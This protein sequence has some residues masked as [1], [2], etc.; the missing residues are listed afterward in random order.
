MKRIVFNARTAEYKVLACILA[1][2]EYSN[3]KTKQNFLGVRITGYHKKKKNKH[4]F[5][6]KDKVPPGT[7]GIISF[8]RQTHNERTHF[9]F[10]MLSKIKQDYKVQTNHSLTSQC[11]YSFLYHV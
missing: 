9:V 5:S 2:R 10:R 6:F 4:I 7:L 11:Q 3:C 1:V 8:F